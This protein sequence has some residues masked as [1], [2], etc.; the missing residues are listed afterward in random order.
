MFNQEVQMRTILVHRGPIDP[1]MGAEGY[2]DGTDASLLAQID[3]S[4]LTPRER[5]EI[6][7]IHGDVLK[8]KPSV[9]PART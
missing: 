1:Y 5:R 4:K 7:M 3:S 6:S 9:K 2:F 8:T